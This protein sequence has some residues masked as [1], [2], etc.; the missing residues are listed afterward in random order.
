MLWESRALTVGNASGSLGM[1]PPLIEAGRSAM[2]RAASTST[3]A[4]ESLVVA[5]PAALAPEVALPTPDEGCRVGVPATGGGFEPAHDVGRR[6]RGLAFECA[7]HEDALDGLGHVQ[8]GAAQWRIQRHHAMLDQPEDER[9]GLVAAQIVED[10]EQPQWRQ[11]FRE[12][13]LDGEARLPPLPR[14]AALLLGLGWRLRQRRQ[15]RRQLGLEPGVQDHVWSTRHP[16]DV[17]L[18]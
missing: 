15:N 1:N 11:A 2:D 16:L 9:G 10:Q 13:E 6:V 3:G 14:G 12:R 7:A 5:Q 8:P 18:P 4:A 17:H